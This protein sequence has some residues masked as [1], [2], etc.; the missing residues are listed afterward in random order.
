VR[1][2]R[3]DLLFAQLG[4]GDDDSALSSSIVRRQVDLDGGLGFD[5]LIDVGNLFASGRASR[6]FESLG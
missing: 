6:G 4:D 1:G 3:V 2:A 5:A